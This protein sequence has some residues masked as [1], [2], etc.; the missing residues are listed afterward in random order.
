MEDRQ[1]EWRLD[2]FARTVAWCQENG[3]YAKGHPLFWSIP[4]CLPEWVKRYDQETFWRFAEVRVRNLV[5]RFRGRVRCWDAVNEPLWEA[6]PA[7]LA[8]RRW[9]QM[10]STETLV[11]YIAPVLRWARQEDPA[12]LL[13]INDYGLEEDARGGQ[14][15]LGSDGQPVTPA[16]Q[17][18]RFVALMKALH[19]AGT[20]PD[21][22]GM[23][24]HT[25]WVTPSVQWRV[26]DE[27]AST[28]LPL[29][30]TEYWAAVEPLRAL[31][32]P[33]AE[34]EARLAQHLTET[35]TVAYGHP[36][37]QGFFFWGLM[38]AA[39]V[40]HGEFSSHE[41]KPCFEAVRRLLHEEWRTR[42]SLVSGADGLLR[43]PAFAGEYELSYALPDGTPKAL[44][45]THEP[46]QGGPLTVVLPHRPAFC[47]T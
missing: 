37:M 7:H 16:R 21:L 23:Q 13:V 24:A 14:E 8:T 34:V 47:T 30:V 38:D 41:T 29:Q 43:T 2:N 40:W 31:G 1:G 5:A 4:K 28:G 26:Y 9:P 17:R 39:I 45:L 33:P 36:A 35:L 10:E 12:A 3:L 19:Q 27:L 18:A 6:A 32:L 15:R 20:P 44:R 46:A 42:A 11:Q 22:L 25:G